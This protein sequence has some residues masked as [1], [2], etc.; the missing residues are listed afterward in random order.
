M[1]V[2]IP[3]NYI[4][5][6]GLRI[7]FHRALSLAKKNEDLHSI[8]VELIDRFGELP[9]PVRLLVKIHSI[10]ILAEEAG[11]K[12]IKSDGERLICAYAK[13][14][15]DYYK[16]GSRFPRLT[17]KSAKPKLSEIQKFLKNL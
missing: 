16:I 4:G 11:F 1:T 14:E 12:S 5:D 3:Q 6:A 7:H 8:Q 13:N 17:Q 15:K 2:S 10:R 9:S